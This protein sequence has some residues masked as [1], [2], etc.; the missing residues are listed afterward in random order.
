[1]F[2]IVFAHGLEGSPEGRKIQYLRTNGFDVRAPDGRGLALAARYEGLDLST[3][4][5]GILLIGSS[6]GGLAAAH[7]AATHPDR[8]VGLLLLAPALH[9]SEEPVTDVDRLFPPNGV[10]TILIHGVRDTVVPIDASRRYAAHGARLIETDDDHALR[11]SMDEMVAVVRE[12][13]AN[14]SR[15]LDER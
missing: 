14:V 7:L 3:K 12:L 5:G 4:S 10:P 8:F 2:P 13:M 15:S 9:Y 11:E 6:Y 1:M